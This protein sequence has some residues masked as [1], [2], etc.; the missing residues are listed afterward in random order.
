[1]DGEGFEPPVL[2]YNT[3]VFKTGTLNLSDTHPFQKKEQNWILKTS[4]RV[5]RLSIFGN[6]KVLE[7]GK[8]NKKRT[9][10]PVGNF[11]QGVPTLYFVLAYAHLPRSNNKER[12]SKQVKRWV[13]GGVADMFLPSKFF[14]CAPAAQT[15]FRFFRND[16]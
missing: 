7:L 14:C 16:S 11:V 15:P 12:F 3:P 13:G 9:R 2:H 1:M 10:A 5:L 6:Y 4:Q 8:E